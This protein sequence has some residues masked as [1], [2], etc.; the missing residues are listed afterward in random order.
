MDAKNKDGRNNNC[1]KSHQSQ[2]AQF[3]PVRRN[4]GVMAQFW[5]TNFDLGDGG[6]AQPLAFDS[7]FQDALLGIK[8]RPARREKEQLVGWQRMG[9]LDCRRRLCSGAFPGTGALP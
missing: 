2:Y 6:P 9:V 4:I 1:A 3:N 7:A 5:Q 8:R